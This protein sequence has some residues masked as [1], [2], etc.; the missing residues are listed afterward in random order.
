MIVKIISNQ[1]NP[2]RQ[3]H[4]MTIIMTIL[5]IVKC[6]VAHLSILHFKSFTCIS[7]TPWKFL[8]FKEC[9][10]LSC[11]IRYAALSNICVAAATAAPN[12]FCLW[13]RSIVHWPR[14][15][16]TT[17]YTICY[18]LYCTIRLTS[19]K[20]CRTMVFFWNIC[21]L[22]RAYFIFFQLYEINFW[23]KTWLICFPPINPNP[24][25][26]P[27][28]PVLVDVAAF[29]PF[30]STNILMRLW[31]HLPPHLP[32]VPFSALLLLLVLVGVE[33]SATSAFT[34]ILMKT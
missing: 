28:L 8:H 4:K 23:Q 10:Y 5:H 2:R 21:I 26:D 29:A 34:N 9:N 1:T 22:K 27:S 15:H 18:S 33:V 32:H 17:C 19:V 20:S 16:V 13:K 11:S 31:M 14:I 3:N 25:F 6:I 7:A 24:L 30:A 12:L